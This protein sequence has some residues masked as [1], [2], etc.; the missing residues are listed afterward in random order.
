MLQH[1][2]QPITLAMRTLQMS[3]IRGHQEYESLGLMSPIAP[4]APLLVLPLSLA[5]L[6]VTWSE[7]S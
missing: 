5:D 2:G 1:L 4:R 6:K 7:W 3:Q